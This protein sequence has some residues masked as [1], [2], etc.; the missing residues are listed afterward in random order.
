MGSSRIGWS[1]ASI[2]AVHA[3]RDTPLIRM[4]QEPQT[5][6]RHARS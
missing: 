6:S 5:S 1:S 3:I 2:R 4:A